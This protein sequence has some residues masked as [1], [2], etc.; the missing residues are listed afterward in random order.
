MDLELTKKLIAVRRFAV[1]DNKAPTYALQTD[2][3]EA[4][5]TLC[6]LVAEVAGSDDCGQCE[7]CRSV[8]ALRHTLS[9]EIRKNMS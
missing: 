3:I 4:M 9:S 1:L 7:G 6:V 8:I 5:L 2:T